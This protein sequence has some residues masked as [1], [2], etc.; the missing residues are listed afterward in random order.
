MEHATQVFAAISLLVIGLSHLVQPRAW[1]SFYQTLAAWG[2]TGAFV[3]GFLCLNFGGIIVAFHNVWQ[4]P[5][6]VL[7]LI[8]WAQVLKGLGRF[9][10][11]QLAVRVMQRASPE[12][13]WF[14][15]VGGVFALALS[16]FVW[17]LR[18]QAQ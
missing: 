1:V 4:G 2:T 5:A 15:Q 3:E 8:G 13:G 17:W 14:F 7:T 11:P 10:A 18:F 9:L 12:R 6:V 16:A